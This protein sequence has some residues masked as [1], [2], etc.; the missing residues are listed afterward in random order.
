M[1]S[2][3][4]KCTFLLCSQHKYE[5]TVC[6]IYWN[7]SLIRSLY[8]MICKNKAVYMAFG[9]WKLDEAPHFSCE[10]TSPLPRQFLAQG[11]THTIAV[12]LVW[13]KLARVQNRGFNLCLTLNIAINQKYR[14]RTRQKVW[15]LKWKTELDYHMRYYRWKH[16][17]KVSIFLIFWSNWKKKKHILHFQK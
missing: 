17:C 4:D 5:L 15:N 12:V 3:L 13:V 11:Y 14:M 7:L 10:E 9:I 16:F 1:G 6:Q 2:F 8:G